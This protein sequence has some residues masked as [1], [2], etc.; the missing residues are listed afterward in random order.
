[1][2]HPES[3]QVPKS[4]EIQPRF[5]LWDAETVILVTTFLVFGGIIDHPL[6]G[7]GIGCLLSALWARF[8]QAKAKSYALHLAYWHL[9]VVRLET[10]PPSFKRHLT[11]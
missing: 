6:I 2:S 9:N 10:A 5:L 4:L 11:S 1:M 8:S 7:G 3:V